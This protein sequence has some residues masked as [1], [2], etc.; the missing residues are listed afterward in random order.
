MTETLYFSH[1]NDPNVN[2]ILI[3][4]RLLNRTLPTQ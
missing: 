2:Q 3:T 1:K 4:A